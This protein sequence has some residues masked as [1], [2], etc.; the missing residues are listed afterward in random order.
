MTMEDLRAELEKSFQSSNDQILYLNLNEY[1]DESRLI[2]DLFECDKF[3]TWRSGAHVLHMLLD[4]LDE[5]RIRIPQ[6]AAILINRFN[7]LQSKI[8]RLRI[9]IACRT[10]DWPI[11]LEK[12]LPELLGENNF[13][14]YELSPLRRK[15][16]QA[17]IEVEGIDSRQFFAELN[18]TESV[19]LAIKPITLSFLISVFKSQGRFPNTRLELYEVGCTRL[20]EELNSSRRDLRLERGTGQLSAEQR[21]TIASRIAAV[22]IFCRKPIIFTQFWDII[23]SSTK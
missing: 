1:G 14:A 17:A 20:C 21:V 13:G 6:V 18:R 11:T 19:P 2:R 15:D 12:L 10:A 7:Q 5:C 8:S 16:V 4:S 9:R 3:T 22:S 23:W